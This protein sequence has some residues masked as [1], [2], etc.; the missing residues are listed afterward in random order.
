MVQNV[1]GTKSLWYEKPGSQFM[2]SCTDVCT[3][4]APAVRIH[5]RHTES[6]SVQVHQSRAFHVIVSDRMTLERSVKVMRCG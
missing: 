6:L 3:K 4:P 2:H 5:V 1:Y